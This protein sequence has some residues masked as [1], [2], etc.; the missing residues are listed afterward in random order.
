MAITSAF[1]DVEVPVV[2]VWTLSMVHQKPYSED[3]EIFI[4]LE[5]GRSLNL[6]QLRAL[7]IQFGQGLKHMFGWAKGDVLS[8][9]SSNCVETPVVNLGLHWAGGVASPANPT[10]TP[11]ELARQLKDSGSKALITQVPYLDAALEAARDANLSQDRII[12]I[13]DSLHEGF[14]HWTDITAKSAWFTPTKTP[15]DPKKDLAY[16]VYSSG[17]TGLPKGVALTHENVVAN[18]SQ[19]G[20]LDLKLLNWDI[21]SHLG[22]LPF[23]H[24]YGL[25]V[26]IGVTILTGARC[27]VMPR[28]DL[29]KACQAIQDRGITFSYIP[30]PIV[31]ALGKHPAVDRYDLSTLRWLNSGAAPVSKELVLAVWD[32]LKVGVKQGYG[33]SETSPTTHTQFPDEWFRFQGSVG[34]LL[35]NMKARIVDDEGRDVKEGDSGELLVKGPNV[36]GGYWNRPD[37]KK[38]TFTEDGWFKTGDVVRVDKKGHFYITDRIKELIKYKGFQVPPAELEEIIHGH[39]KVADCCVVGVW[40]EEEHTEVPRAYIVPETGI[41]PSEEFGIELVQWLSGRVAPPKRLRGGVRF[42]N[43]IPKSQ[44]GKVLR[45]VLQEQGRKEDQ[46]PKAKL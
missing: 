35:P 3:H 8:I 38:D 17:T 14:K 6:A 19:V 31:L 23:F 24:I 40:N 1:S 36:F 20:P 43:E 22:V 29:E 12:L 18:M 16:L 25:S 46:A 34:R 4:D 27:Y 10:Y 33:L 37:L 28:W 15:V 11:G 2:D 26:V 32:R 5:T 21:D 9:Y 13:G 39:E 42:I 45:R 44:S 41:Q 30:P 7:S